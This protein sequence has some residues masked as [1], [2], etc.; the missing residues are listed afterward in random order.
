MRAD[1]R[2]LRRGEGAD[3][4]SGEGHPRRTQICAKICAWCAN[5]RCTEKEDFIQDVNLG[6]KTPSLEPKKNQYDRDLLANLSRAYP[7]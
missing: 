7:S 2:R 6:R 1:G 3:E 4:R 5:L